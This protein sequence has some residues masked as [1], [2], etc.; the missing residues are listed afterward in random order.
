VKS[1]SVFVQIRELVKDIPKG[2]VSTYGNVAEA[3]GI[4][5]ARVVGWALRGNQNKEIPCH[6][7]IQAG[8]TLSPH[9]SLGGW[10]E[11]KNRLTKDGVKFSDSRKVD[12]QECFWDLTKKLTRK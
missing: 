7:V 11:Q 9:F 6:R 8:G 3:A 2:K 10:Q 12:L 5:V 1:T 4:K